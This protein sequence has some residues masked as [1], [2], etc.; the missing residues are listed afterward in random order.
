MFVGKED[1]PYGKTNMVTPKASLF[2]YTFKDTT[3]TK[4]AFYNWLDCFGS[5]CDVIKL[6]ED[7]DAIKTPPMY[8]LVYDTTIVIVEYL[9]EHEKNDWGTFQDSLLNKFGKDYRYAIN[10]DCGG[11]LKWK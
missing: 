8:T 5:D 1:V 4:N 10:I 11:P 6:G 2:Y 7:V 9:C 3:A